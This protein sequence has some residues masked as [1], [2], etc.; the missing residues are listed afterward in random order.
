MTGLPDS[1]ASL[2]EVTGRVFG[3]LP[4]PMSPVG[5]RLWSQCRWSFRADAT[6]VQIARELL[7][8]PAPYDLLAVCVS[9]ADVTGRRFWRYMH[10]GEYTNRPSPKQTANFGR[11]IQAYYKYIDQMLDDLISLAG[12][13][14]RVILVSDHGMATFNAN[15]AFSQD[16][17]LSQLNSGHHRSAEPG[18]IIAAGPGIA[19]RSSPVRIRRLER[20]DLQPLAT[21]SI[22]QRNEQRIILAVLRKHPP[23]GEPPT[24]HLFF[25]RWYH[26]HFI[27]VLA[28]FSVHL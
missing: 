2:G 4:Y 21:A 23:L 1:R 20:F 7:Q 24:D 17:P 12:R 11:I 14:A 18:L 15:G 27:G 9:G 5:E 22:A 10:P 19:M 3:A 8:E 13:D 6:S 25:A 16:D 26:G 28:P